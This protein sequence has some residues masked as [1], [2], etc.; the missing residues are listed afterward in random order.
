LIATETIAPQ[1]APP[2]RPS[3][4]ETPPRTLTAYAL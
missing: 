4:I 1:I 2:S 3:Q